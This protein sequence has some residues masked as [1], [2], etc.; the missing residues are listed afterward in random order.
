M[1]DILLA[2]FN[3]GKFLDEQIRSIENQSF[4]DWRIIIRDD[5]SSD[6]TIDILQNWKNILRDKMI[7]LVD[8]NSGLGV[9]KN[10][11]ILMGRSE[12]DYVMFCDQDDYWL[13]DK[14]AKSFGFLVNVENL[15]GKSSPIL[16]CCDLEIVN[17]NLESLAKSFWE[18]RKDDPIILNDYQKLIA[19]SVVTGNTMILNRAAVRVSWPIDTDF[20]LYD[21]WISIKVAYYGKVYFLPESLVKYRQHSQNVLG[22]FQLNSKYLIGKVRHLPFYIGSWFNLKKELNLEFSIFKV[23]SFKIVYNLK[24]LLK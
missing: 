22:S 5:G 19:Q 6:N 14:I 9:N 23:F 20:F 18:L 12:A 15:I 11:S 24:K 2:T 8:S 1:I 4:T 17:Q 16:I 21:Q 10:F 13:P 7:I 3:G